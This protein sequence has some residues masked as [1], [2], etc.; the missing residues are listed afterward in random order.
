MFDEKAIESYKQVTAPPELKNRVMKSYQTGHA[1]SNNIRLYRSLSLVAACLVLVFAVSVFAGRDGGRIP[2]T[3]NGTTIS[4]TPMAISTVGPMTAL[5]DGSEDTGIM[6]AS[7][8]RAMQPQVSI[9]LVVECT[10][11]TKIAVSDGEMQVF[12]VNTGELLFAGSEYIAE[13]TVSLWWNV[14]AE[15]SAEE[16]A[17]YLHMTA[18]GKTQT[19]QL[20]YEETDGVWMIYQK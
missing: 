1:K 12:D 17:P 10:S 8:G 4:E 14:E 15:E 18:K 5:A 13:G 19:L 7:F 11:E 20:Q 2:V 3:M 16:G 6:T 9:P